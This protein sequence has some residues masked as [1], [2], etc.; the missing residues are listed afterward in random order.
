MKRYLTDIAFGLAC[1]CLLAAMMT[2]MAAFWAAASPALAD[3][4]AHVI[5]F[6]ALA[7]EVA[8]WALNALAIIATPV[9]LW[10]AHRVMAWLGI[11]SR[12]SQERVDE[13]VR[14]YLEPVVLRGIQLA[15]SRAGLL[16]GKASIEV[17]SALIAE[18]AQYAIDSVPGALKHFGL[19][20]ERLKSYVE[21]RLDD[22]WSTG[23]SLD[24]AAP[25]AGA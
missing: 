6:G 24:I 19:D 11:K 20:D 14:G 16:S 25:G 17:R 3:D 7:G 23:G 1:L 5:S 9:L 10:A 8:G 12:E 18:A 21:A 2:A 15:K 22:W 13:I 4:G